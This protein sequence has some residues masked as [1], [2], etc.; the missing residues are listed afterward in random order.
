MKKLLLSSIMLCSLFCK[1]Q[2]LKK[3]GWAVVYDS[4][5]VEK[6]MLIKVI[7][8]ENG[9]I[10][11]VL[12]VPLNTQAH[13]TVTPSL[14]LLTGKNVFIDTL[15]SAII[16]HEPVKI[17]TIPCIMLVSD[18][19]LRG[20][21]YSTNGTL[22]YYNHGSIFWIKGYYIQRSDYKGTRPLDENKKPL[23]LNIVIW[24]SRELKP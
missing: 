11:T 14:N 17:D 22:D 8:F 21:V 15:S 10:D 16:W 7:K 18:T 9:R 13:D 4:M 6:E 5:L 12:K 20:K 3:T 24:Q 1:G 19:S 2:A 23:P